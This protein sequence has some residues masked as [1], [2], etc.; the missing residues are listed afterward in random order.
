[1]PRIPIVAAV[2]GAVL[3]T[4]VTVATVAA[5]TG[6]TRTDVDEPRDVSPTHTQDTTAPTTP[7]TSD[8]SPPATSFQPASGHD[9]LTAVPAA[10]SVSAGLP[11]DGGDF[12]RVSE[13]VT[14][15]F[16]DAEAFGEDAAVDVRRDGATGPEYGDR[17]DLRVFADDRAAH[18][19]VARAADAA[20]A[21]PEEL[22][23][24]TR[25]LHSVAVVD[26]VGEESVR[27]L[28]TYETDGMVNAGA[29]WW[30]VVRVGNAVLLTA[31]G[32]EYIPG[33]TL[34]QGVREHQQL[35]SPIVD[36]MCVFSA[37]GCPGSGE[38]IPADFPLAAGWPADSEAE[39]GRRYGLKGPN[40]QLP[41]LEFAYCRAD[42]TALG[43]TDALR[44][45]WTNVEDY[46][47]RALL[48]FADE[49]DASGFVEDFVTSWTS[50]PRSPSGAGYA[51]VHDTVGT[52]LGDESTALASWTEYAGAPA[53][54]LQVV[55]VVR[56]GDA[57][58][59]DSSA[60]EGSRSG[61]EEQVSGQ[62]AELAPVVDAMSRLGR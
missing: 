29:T 9:W 21:C 61:V 62:G 5:L 6:P 12:T 25:W 46:R 8:A 23:S 55:H 42:F 49:T 34:G 38:D 11:D 7:A 18:A 56:V 51:A 41:P 17:R 47:G 53:I 14:G 15:S 24:V 37:A 20:R 48:T 13:A 19:F 1:M 32:G 22:H 44:A 4:V 43:G 58:L 35:I 3:A 33:E 57:V 60:N 26:G 16:C 40:D 45:D 31:T 59:I 36:S 39:P 2:G 28:R 27:I 50:C 52:D 10:L 54:G 30:D